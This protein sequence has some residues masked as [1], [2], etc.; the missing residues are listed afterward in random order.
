MRVWYDVSGIYN[1]TGNFTG[2]QR[3]VYNLAKEL[4]ASNAD[5]GYF[6]YRH[7]SFHEVDFKE[8]DERLKANIK[9]PVY[10]ASVSKKL[11]LRKVQHYMMVGL[12]S[13]VR[14]TPLEGPARSVYSSMRKSYRSVR[15]SSQRANPILSP[16]SAG[17]VVVV[18]DGNWQFGGYA[19]AI[20]VVKSRIT[21][22][23]V[24]FVHDLTALR[25]PA[26]VNPGAERIIGGYFKELFPVTDLL[27]AV[28]KSTKRDIEWFA[29][30]SNL[31][32]PT[33]DVLI[34]GD[35]NL[36]KASTQTAKEPSIV[37]PQ[38]FILAVGTIE[39]RKNYTILYYTYK[40]AQERGI[41][42]PHL[43]IAG[44]KGWM[45][46]EAYALLTKDVDLLDKITVLL[47]P[48]DQELA[49]L[50]DKCQFTVFPSFYEGWGLPVGESLAHDRIC[51]SSN[52][53][54]MPEV[55]GNMV[56]YISPYDPAEIMK[57][58]LDYMNPA[59]KKAASAKIAGYKTRTW[60][61]CADSLIDML[62][63]E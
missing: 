41:E 24:H 58:I 49:W 61:D 21:F 47:G 29:R 26:L 4:Y 42:L 39:I 17:D 40:L 59:T 13:G 51:I 50:Y 43:V 57:A 5:I 14:S 31:K 37:I 45:A 55:G 28:S 9:I 35:D 18:V 27:V 16:F 15:G 8:L 56:R 62:Q 36:S 2:V 20:K 34:L 19:S 11:N 7:G 6:I 10:T 60:K 22:K 48:S 25:N 63:H 33:T 3:V 44:R 32:M 12:K 38:P 23:L 1:W 53:S 52:T 30:R 54:S 46:E